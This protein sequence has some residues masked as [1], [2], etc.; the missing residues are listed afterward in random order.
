MPRVGV[1]F[2]LQAYRPNANALSTQAK[3]AG[4]LD[5]QTDREKITPKNRQTM[6]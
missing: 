5:K 2:T 3:R 6:R 1:S 4:K